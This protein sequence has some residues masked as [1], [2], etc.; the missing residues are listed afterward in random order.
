M[1]ERFL[2]ADVGGTNTRVGLGDASGI[3]LHTVQNFR[4][5][6]HADFTGVLTRYL[7]QHPG[8]I[9]ALCA[10]VAGPVRGG[11]AQLTNL[12]WFIDASDVQQATG[13]GSVH[14]INDLQAQGYALDD[15]PTD[16]ISALFP[17]APPPPRATRLVMGLGTGCNIAVVHHTAQGLFVPP[18]ETGHTTLPHMEGEAGNL[19][20]YLSQTHFHKPIEAALSGT[21]LPRIYR[22]ISG[23]TLAAPDII[24]RHVDGNVEATSA[25]S[26]FTEI[27]GTVAGNIVLSHLPMGGLYFIGGTARAVA[28]HL[29]ELGFLTHFTAK[30]PYTPI[31]EDTPVFLIDDDTAALHGCARYLLQSLHQPVT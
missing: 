1:T 7:E 30:G 22:N 26:L 10:G 14:L 28:P 3:D 21:G 24:A 13:A 4:N 19:V 18:S 31:L 5:A 6:D 16:S 11:N 12:D 2:L 27:L 9:A 23:K 17:G 29:A 25:L 8:P 20:A 15:L